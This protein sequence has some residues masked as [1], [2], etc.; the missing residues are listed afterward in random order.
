MLIASSR[1]LLQETFESKRLPNSRSTIDLKPATPGLYYCRRAGLAH[2]VIVVMHGRSRHQ[3]ARL[4]NPLGA[5]PRGGR[6]RKR[7]T[8]RSQMRVGVVTR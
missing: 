8:A 6:S 5:R 7:A 2:Q 3:A 1:V 4:G